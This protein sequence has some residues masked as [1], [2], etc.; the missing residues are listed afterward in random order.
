MRMARRGELLEGPWRGC[1]GRR[2]FSRARA[3]PFALA[4]DAREIF[5]PFVIEAAAK[6]H[7]VVG[8]PKRIRALWR[9]QLVERF[10]QSGRAIDELC[11]RAW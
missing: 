10:H 4:I 6:A 2:R 9:E 1:K 11:V 8:A 3:G 7:R 5:V